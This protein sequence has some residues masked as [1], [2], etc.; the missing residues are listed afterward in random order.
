MIH[1]QDRLVTPLH[2]WQ[3]PYKGYIKVAQSYRSR[4]YD[5]IHALKTPYERTRWAIVHEI[6]NR[7]TLTCFYLCYLVGVNG[8]VYELTKNGSLRQV[9]P[10]R[11]DLS[12][13]A[14]PDTGLWFWSSVEAA[15]FRF[16]DQSLLEAMRSEF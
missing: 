11:M 5:T 16:P 10:Q 2:A 4:G 9:S 1:G 15:G 14:V 13:H 7:D 8:G 12:L 6:Q 3:N